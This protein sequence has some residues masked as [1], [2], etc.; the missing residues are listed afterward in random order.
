M[1]SKVRIV[2][3]FHLIWL[4]PNTDQSSE[5]MNQ[6]QTIF[7]TIHK[8]NHVDQCI[9]FL[10]DIQCEKTFMII[11]NSSNQ[12]LISLIH[13]ISQLYSIYIYD[14]ERSSN[15]DEWINNWSKI[16]GLFQQDTS[17]INSLKQEVRQC[18]E[19]SISISIIPSDVES[20]KNLNQL[21]PTFI[22][23]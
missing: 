18:D 10:T 17:L 21:D 23:T 8:F 12:K 11:S 22:Y 13:D 20:N 9:D 3:N 5:T 15:D 1:S 6:L 4:N 2:Q 19:N 16:K 7:Q 14:V